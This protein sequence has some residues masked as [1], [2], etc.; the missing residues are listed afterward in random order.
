MRQTAQR[1][2]PPPSIACHPP[3]PRSSCLPPSPARFFPSSCGFDVFAHLTRHDIRALRCVNRDFSTLVSPADHLYLPKRNVDPD[4]DY[5]YEPEP[6]TCRRSCFYVS[7]TMLDLA[8]PLRLVYRNAPT[9]SS[10]R[11]HSILIHRRARVRVHSALGAPHRPR[12]RER[13][14]SPLRRGWTNHR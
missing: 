10:Q 2:S 9:I 3:R 14:P 11:E 1:T 4:S 13:Q 6:A 12:A 7:P 8:R 5:D